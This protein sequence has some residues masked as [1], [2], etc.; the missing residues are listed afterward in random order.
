[1]RKYKLCKSISDDFMYVYSPACKAYKEFVVEDD[2]IHNS[3]NEEINDWDYI[4]IVTKDKYTSGVTVKTKCAFEKFGAPLIVFTDDIF[5]GKDGRPTYGHHFEIVAYE[6]GINIWS[7]VPWWERT[8]RPIKSERIGFIE[9]PVDANAL[10]ELEVK[11]EK[12]KIIATL[13]GKTVDV[14]YSSI[15]EEFHVGITA[16]E[17]VNK[18][19]E[20]VID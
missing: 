4:S 12:G 13:C 15:P 7:I 5:E 3:F 17:G 6:D 20:F 11:I 9:F 18:F 14:E 19:T 1:M 2:C 10:V 8:E 16:C